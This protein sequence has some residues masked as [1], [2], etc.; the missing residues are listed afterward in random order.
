M[1]FIHA[2][3][4]AAGLA[5][6]L[7]IVIHLLFRQRTR[8]V[9]IGSIR[10]LQQAVK[11]HRRS[12]RVRQWLL[13]AL[14]MLAVL[15]LAALFAR[16]YWDQTEKQALEREVVLL[17]DRS[18][19]MGTVGN[20]GKNSLALAIEQA[21]AEL[22]QLPAQVIMHIAV[23]DAGGVKEI[24]VD[25]LAKLT[26][27]E[28]ATDHA[29]AIEW[30][31]DVLQQSQRSQREIILFTDLQ[32]SGLTNFPQM[33]PENITFSVR[34][35]GQT[36]PSNL[37]IVAAEASQ[38]EIRPDSPGTIRA[39]VRNFSALPAR[40]VELH[41]EL[42]GPTGKLNAEKEFE[43]AA[44]GTATIELPIA[45]K[46]DGVYRGKLELLT[47]NTGRRDSL[48]IDNRRW[49]AFE[50]RQPERVLLVD[51]DEGR[52]VF[53]NETYYLETALRIRSDE[54]SGRLRSF[55]TERIVWENGSGFP[56]LD[57]YRAV[58]LAN[59]RRLTNDDAARLKSYVEAGGNLLIFGGDQVSQAALTP[60]QQAELL[61]GEVAA[62]TNENTIRITDWAKKHAAL[63]C[64]NDPH[65]GDLRRIQLQQSLPIAK[66]ASKSVAL[67]MSNEHTIAA[68]RT[69]QKG[70]VIYLGFTA[71]RDW[72]DLP[73]SRLYVPFVRQLLAHLTNQLADRSLIAEKVVMK[74]DERT[75][76]TEQAGKWQVV[77]LDPRES[78][79][80]RS[81]AEDFQ[82]LFGGAGSADKSSAEKVSLAL[83]MPPDS[84]RPDEIWKAIAWLL[85]F[86]LAAETLL[87]SRVHA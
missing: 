79:P 20:S 4:L 86:I 53:Q 62:N 61:P 29:L 47:S 13:L 48:L 1:N 44:H 25:E 27:S 37:A 36:L 40:S 50:A 60:L 38:I 7:P 12:R 31:R 76:L 28:A 65:F 84:L 51:G 10:F 78:A 8:D 56:R 59:V 6:A 41:A 74:S 66:L 81:A 77:N 52:A 9:S 35:C 24:A 75:G 11:E 72:T 39:T 21:Q 58:V 23:C 80:D 18:A 5:V 55:E 14:R 83:L 33:L 85:L 45:A 71:D 2:S 73:Q 57:G 87:A 64:F 30:A 63:A 3:F 70:R 26:T 43:I 54:A 34:D 68:E 15:L 82:K 67:L 46:S 17:V 49:I 22:K 69:V 42:D 32:R 19:S 16:P